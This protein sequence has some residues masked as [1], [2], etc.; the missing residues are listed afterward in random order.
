MNYFRY[1]RLPVIT[2]V[3]M[4]FSDCQSSR[5][6]K[7]TNLSDIAVNEEVART[8]RNF[9]GFGAMSDNSQPT[10]ADRAL[11]AFKYPDDLRLDLVLS[12]PRVSQPV[13]INFDHRGRLWVVQY[14]QY[15][16]PKG[17]KV[18]R[19]DE[20]LRIQYND[21]PLPPPNGLRGADKITIFEDTNGDGKYDKA[22]DAITGLNIATSVVLGRKKVWVLSPPY[23]LAYPDPD[24]DG[25]PDGDPTVHLEGF[26]LE[27]THAVANSLRWGPDGWLYGAQGSTTTANINSR[28]S[29]NVAFQGQAIWRYH[30]ETSVF[31]VFAEGGGNTFHVEIDDKGRIYSGDNG[32]SRGQYYKQGAYYQRNLDKHGPYT[33]PYTFGYLPNMKHEGEKKRFTHG[34]IRYQGGNLPERYHDRMLAVNPLHGYLQLASIAKNGSSFSVSDQE[35]ILSTDDR[36]FRP[37]DIKAGPDGAVYLADWYDSRLTHVDARDTWHKTS[38]RIYRLRKN[39]NTPALTRQFDLTKYSGDE[40]IA[41]LSSRNNWFRQEALRILGD[42]K[43]RKLLPKLTD[44]LQSDTAQIALQA[45]WAINLSGGF[46]Q[47]IADIALTH[48]DSFVRMWGVRLLGDAGT[49]T[50]EQGKKLAALARTEPHPEVRSQLASTAK[51]L[52][53]REAIPV[54][55]QLMRHD[56]DASDP[57]IPMLIWWGIEAKIGSDR[58]AVI[59]LFEDKS[60]WK[61]SIVNELIAGLLARRLVTEGTRE[62]LDACTAFLKLAPEARYQKMVT[63]GIQKGLIGMESLEL[64][65]ELVQMISASGGGPG[66]GLSILMQ[67]R[68]RDPEA[69]QKA[70]GIIRDNRADSKERLAYIRVLGETF[71][72]EA[73]PVLLN[74]VGS[75]ESSVPIKQA[76]LR[77]LQRY[78]D[79]SIAAKII[80]I[81]PKR[82]QPN[83]ALKAETLSLLTSRP[84]WANQLLDSIESGNGI[85]KSDLD[86]HIILRLKLIDAPGFTQRVQR[87]LPESRSVTS[88]QKM[89]QIKSVSKLLQK[90]Q[91]SV[92]HGKVIFQ[93][94]CGACHRLFDEGGD[95]GPDLTGYDRRNI[96]DLLFNTINPNADI[97]EGYVYNQVTTKDGRVLLGK[98][99]ERSGATITIQPVGGN[100]ITLA[101]KQIVKMEAQKNSMM[102]ERLLDDLSEEQIRDLFSYIISIKP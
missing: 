43:D 57:D 63:D 52:P 82:L 30:P 91:G 77:S 98:I 46:D 47:Q 66:A 40:L 94:V 22:T 89:E 70:S 59:S 17:L 37:V 76:A 86:S 51:R 79:E 65:G 29:K 39:D 53:A 84:D 49:V 74:L 102:P 27:D 61:A 55:G 68:Q 96:N 6:R 12:E 15:P 64:P 62:S 34:W 33:N 81:Y 48:H 71:I 35:H 24:E 10:S 45:L 41:L 83:T 7:P 97:R 19:I 60:L 4:L 42:R 73:V 72:P 5:T 13:F 99:V 69:F 36:W 90:G 101:E 11:L 56:A 31:E 50:A 26:G 28:A 16:Y 21:K 100:A 54:L 93:N 20:Y 25:L 85:D 14:N 38:G 2:L 3:C 58:N 75:T 78:P 44:L 18:E 95:I 32:T 8:L 88:D 67:L 87:V 23:L 1:V 9:E 92:E 80:E